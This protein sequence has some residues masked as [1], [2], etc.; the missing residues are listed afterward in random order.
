MFVGPHRCTQCI[1]SD[2]SCKHVCLRFIRILR[3]PVRIVF[4]YVTSPLKYRRIYHCEQHAPLPSALSD[5]K[6]LIKYRSPLLSR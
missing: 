5:V 4:M 2:T 1:L 6:I 3:V